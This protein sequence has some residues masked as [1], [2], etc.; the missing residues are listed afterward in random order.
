LLESF[1]KLHRPVKSLLYFLESFQ[2][3]HFAAWPTTNRFWKVFKRWQCVRMHA[4][5][6]KNNGKLWKRKQKLACGW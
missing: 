5:K 6:T 4:K 3:L 2:K 1:Q